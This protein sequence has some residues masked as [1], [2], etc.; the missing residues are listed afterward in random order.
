MADPIHSVVDPFLVDIDSALGARYS[1]VLYGSAARGDFVAGRSDLNLLLVLEDVGSPVLRSLAPAF[2]AWRRSTQEPP[3][4]LSQAEWAGAGDVFPIEITDMRSAYRVLRGADPL[5]SITVAP[6]DLRRALEREFRG[7]LLRL[8]QGYVA[9][10]TDEA[11][12]GALA[13]ESTGTMLVLYRALLALLGRDAPRDPDALA[14][15][16]G[17][18]AGLQG[19]GLGG[20]VR[21]RGEKAWRCKPAEFEAYV[22]AVARTADFVDHLKLGDSR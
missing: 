12:L 8:R 18:A 20:I 10:A 16:A 21:H 2:S 11:G 6:A 7:K 5:S 19:D 14:V 15:A 3:L 22:D 1:A 13:A 17:E 9:L 4:L